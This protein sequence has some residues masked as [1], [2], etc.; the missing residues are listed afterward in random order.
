MLG[1][2]CVKDSAC[3]W[4]EFVRFGVLRE[5][6]HL[7]RGLGLVMGLCDA[8]WIKGCGLTAL[9]VSLGGYLRS[10]VGFL[11]LTTSWTT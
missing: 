2:I 7:G 6:S 9:R 3:F 4:F 10:S 11:K 8:L 5:R 1:V